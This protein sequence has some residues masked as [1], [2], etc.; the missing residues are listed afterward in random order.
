MKQ[1]RW[2]WVLA[3]VCLWVA[4]GAGGGNLTPVENPESG[5]VKPP[6]VM[7]TMALMSNEAM[8]K[9]AMSA[10][11]AAI[12]K[13][14]SVVHMTAD[15]KMEELRKGTNGWT[16]MP[17]DPSTPSNDPMCLDANSMAWADGWM[18]HKPVVMKGPGF[19]Y[20]LQGGGSASNTD[21]FAKEPPKGQ[22]WMVE[23]PHLMYFPVNAKE[24]ENWTDD[25][26]TG[27]PWVMW[28]GT[29]YAHLMIPA[30]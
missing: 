7:K 27:G 1:V 11:L 23:P 6:K 18:N 9:N 26:K 17:D 4:A 24:L 30:K 8:I 16:C 3:A 14:A 29:P 28:K 21:P 19:A 15:G 25:Q 13:D 12:A 10:G 22:K 5:E 2:V 20:M